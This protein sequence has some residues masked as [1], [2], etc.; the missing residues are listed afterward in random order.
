LKRALIVL[1]LAACNQRDA[2]EAAKA[3]PPPPTEPLA[4][5]V[6]E[7]PPVDVP[8]PPPAPPDASPPAPPA[9]RHDDDA[10]RL[11]ED[12]AK[13]Y[14]DLLTADDPPG[15]NVLDGT[16]RP[17]ADL[18]QQIA[19][20]K[21]SANTVAVGGAARG[22]GGARIGQA[23]TADATPTPR[24]HITVVEKKAFDETSLTPD[25]VVAKIQS[26][27]MAGLRRCYGEVLARNATVHGTITLRL[28]VNEVGRTVRLDVETFDD[29]LES[30][31]KNAIYAWRF[32]IP[33]DQD[34]EATEANLELK[35]G[36]AP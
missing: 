28:T 24:G 9:V 13:R 12:E 22:S 35:L 10:V 3:A 36:L 14:A 1:A 31:V 4:V 8:A 23:G 20:V 30:C 7:S 6:H 19:D 18:D 11:Q 15:G 2:R 34:G 21:D 5:A 16:R 27:Y 33:K 25:V 32:P 26:V 29:D 17:G